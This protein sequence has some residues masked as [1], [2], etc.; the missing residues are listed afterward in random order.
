MIIISHFKREQLG[1]FQSLEI[2]R[3]KDVLN[4]PDILTNSNTDE[5]TYISNT[6]TDAIITPVYETINVDANPRKTDAGILFNVK[7]EFEVN[8]LD[9]NTDALLEQYQEENVLIKATTN[10]NKSIIY[11]SLQ[12]P[13]QFSYSIVHSN[14]L[15]NH[16]KF[17]CKIF[18]NTPQKPVIA[19]V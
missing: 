12:F 7:S 19:I 15:E 17:I 2:I 11:G 6:D 14:K 9:I 10:N 1:G 16:S 18:G 13:L 3:T 4:C 8:Y 5:F